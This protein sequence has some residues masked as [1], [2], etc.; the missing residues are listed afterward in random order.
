MEQRER[1]IISAALKQTK[2]VR[3]AAAKILGIETGTLMR[4]MRFLGIDKKK[5]PE[6]H[7]LTDNKPDGVP[8]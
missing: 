7:W 2:G 3:N 4:R 6:S 1:E 5:K 8:R